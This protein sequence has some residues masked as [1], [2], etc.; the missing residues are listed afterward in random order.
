MLCSGHVLRPPE[1]PY[2]GAGKL[3]VNHRAVPVTLERIGQPLPSIPKIKAKKIVADIRARLSDSE[4]TEKYRIS[5][6]QLENVMEQLVNAQKI[7]RPEITERGPFFDDPANRLQ[8]RR[9]PRAFLRLPMEI[10][11]VGNP[12]QRGLVLDLSP[13][14]FRTHGLSVATGEDR[15]FLMSSH[16]LCQTVGLRATCVWVRWAR[17]YADTA[18]AG[19]KITQISETDRRKL[20]QIMNTLSLGDRNG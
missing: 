2:A 12:P 20:Q 9:F 4:L 16:E 1:H 5:L 3:D 11:A 17:E 15:Q 7:R 10:L 6:Q 8:T 13:K 14:G 18:Q 19:F